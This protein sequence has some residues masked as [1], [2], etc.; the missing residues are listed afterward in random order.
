M[1][2]RGKRRPEEKK[3]KKRILTVFAG[4]DVDDTS[5]RLQKEADLEMES[6]KSVTER[7][8]QRE[9][10]NKRKRRK[11]EE[12]KKEEKNVSVDECVNADHEVL[13]VLSELLTQGSYTFS[14]F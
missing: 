6:P 14:S 8:R 5:Y 13:V 11:E 10:T 12:R 9:R 4:V 1:R 3:M 2:G 7:E